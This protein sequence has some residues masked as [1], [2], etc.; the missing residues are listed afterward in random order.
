METE[1]LLILNGRKSKQSA[2]RK[3][4]WMDTALSQVFRPSAN[5]YV[6]TFCSAVSTFPIHTTFNTM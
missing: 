1:G 2:L 6:V 5:P 4:G 3:D